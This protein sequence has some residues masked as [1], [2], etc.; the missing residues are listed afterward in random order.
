MAQ[1]A[2]L[3]PDALK[4]HKGMGKWI[5]RTWLEKHCPA[6]R[7]FAPKQGFT[8]PIGQWIG[9]QGARLGRLV[10]AQP[11]I[12]EIAYPEKVEA[13]F[14]QSNGRRQGFA[15]WTLLFYALWHRAHIRGLAPEGDVFEALSGL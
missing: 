6:A 9:N 8:V 5:L 13:L 3:L 4:V 7:P 2:F 11:C 15:A 1:A 12:R 10:A 14:R